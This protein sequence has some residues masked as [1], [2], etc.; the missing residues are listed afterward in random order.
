MLEHATPEVGTPDPTQLARYS[1]VRL[2]FNGGAPGMRGYGQTLS[3]LFFCEEKA[4]LALF[5]GTTFYHSQHTA[6]DCCASI[7]Q[8]SR[9]SCCENNMVTN[10]PHAKAR[11][12]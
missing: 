3:K 7:P 6:T 9:S 12:A 10:A 11:L 5:V 4:C 1:A 2:S 8:Q